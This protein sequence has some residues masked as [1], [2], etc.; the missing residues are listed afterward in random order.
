MEIND[1]EYKRLLQDAL[2]YQW[3]VAYFVSDRTD[4]DEAIVAASAIGVDH[5]T[6]VIDAA[7][8]HKT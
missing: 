8:E 6:A 7:M 3:L 5:V 1:I 2:R 4:Q